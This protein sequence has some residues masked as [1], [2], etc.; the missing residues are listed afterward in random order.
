MRMFALVALAT[1][2][3]AGSASAAGKPV[4]GWLTL[5]DS[6]TRNH[7]I[8]DG[9]VWQC[10]VD[11]CRAA[12]TKA[13]PADRTCRRLAAEFGELTGFGFRGETFTAEALAACNESAKG[14]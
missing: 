3:L 4:N 5:K 10:K 1:M 2:A 12:R 6:T 14:R 11:V 8:F 9:V 13:T 7:V